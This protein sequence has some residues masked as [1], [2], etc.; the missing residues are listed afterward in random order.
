MI[1]QSFFEILKY[2]IPSLI[3]SITIYILIRNFLNQM[4]QLQAL[5]QSK[6]Q[7]KGILTLRLQA[8]E[9]LIMFCERMSIDNMVY[10][11]NHADM[12][13]KELKNAMLIAIQQEYEH[14][15]TQQI[16]ISENLWKII[17][18]AKVEL[19]ELVLNSDGET[20]VDL[21]SKIRNQMNANKI[22][23][24]NYAKSAIR[25]EVHLIVKDRA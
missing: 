11:L 4:Y 8:Y 7:N 12:G 5:K 10:R 23:P 18:L 13:V 3:V 24:A 6:R 19:Q 21:I 14:N 15:I 2:T 16:Y 17:Q 9:R 20:A 25:N 22:D 1:T